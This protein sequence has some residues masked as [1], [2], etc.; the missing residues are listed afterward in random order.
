M[1]VYVQFASNKQL[2]LKLCNR[3]LQFGYISRVFVCK[4]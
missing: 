1:E 4:L 2:C 3:F